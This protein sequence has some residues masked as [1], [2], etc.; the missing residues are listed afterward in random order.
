MMAPFSTADGTGVA[1]GRLARAAF[2]FV[3]VT[4]F[5][6]IA[7]LVAGLFGWIRDLL[8]GIQSF[9]GDVVAGLF[10]PLPAV[11][12]ALGNLAEAVGGA[13]VLGFIAAIAVVSILAYGVAWARGLL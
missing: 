6:N 8:G 7:A 1:W 12:R 5:G 11:D 3:V 13:D 4:I 9:V 2:A 10:A